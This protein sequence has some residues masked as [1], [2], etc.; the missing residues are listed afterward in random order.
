MVGGRT[1]AGEPDGGSPAEDR[2]I[3]LS[4]YLGDNADPIIADL[5][6]ALSQ[7]PQLV[8]LGLRARFDPALDGVDRLQGFHEGRFDLAWV[9][10]LHTITRLHPS[11]YR[12]VAAPVFSGSRSPTYHSV[13]VTNNDEV[14]SLEEALDRRCRLVANEAD[15]WSGYRGLAHELRLRGLDPSIMDEAEFTGSHAE[16]IYAVADADPAWICL[17]AIDHTVWNHQQRSTSDRAG[18]VVVVDRTAD[19]PSPPFSVRADLA[20]HVAESLMAALLDPATVR[21]VPGLDRIV[22]AS[23]DTYR[24]MMF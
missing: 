10:G 12:I 7:S 1:G 13:I 22:P 20:P 4:T 21:A 3:S 24:F 8:D 11:P 19:W 18:S 16:S 6:R 2:V 14:D 23:A 9:C 5:T 15:S 17:A